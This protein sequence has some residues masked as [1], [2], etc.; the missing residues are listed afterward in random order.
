LKLYNSQE[1]K[2]KSEITSK[3]NKLKSTKYKILR[4]V[5]KKKFKIL[6][7]ELQKDKN[8]LVLVQY[9]KNKQ[10]GYIDDM[11]E[12]LKDVDVYIGGDKLHMDNIEI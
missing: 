11:F 8:D 10:E 5:W 1:E 6:E 3:E 4:L 2:L 7:E 12:R 9:S